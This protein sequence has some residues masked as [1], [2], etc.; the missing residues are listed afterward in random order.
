M[1]REAEALRDAG[2]EVDVVCMKGES[3][4][5]RELV[6]GIR[7]HRLGGTRR[8]A[9]LGAYVADYATFLVSATVTVARLDH[10][11][12]YAA[13]QVHTMPDV[14]VFSAVV[15][16]LRGARVILDMHEVMP[17]LFATKFGGV[18]GR[19]AA[20]LVTIAERASVGFAD[21]IL[22]VSEPT[23]RV[24]VGRGVRD[25]KLTIVMNAADERLFTPEAADVHDPALVISHGTIVERYGFRTLVRAIP[26]VRERR[27]EARLQ[28]VGDG[29]D[30][31]ELERLVDELALGDCV[32]LLGY[33]PL[34]AIP[35]LV[36]RAAV[37]VAANELDEFT[38]LIVP[39]KLM[40]YVEL[41]VPAVASRSPAVEEY[42]DERSIALFRAGDAADLARTLL[43]VLDDP[44]GS[45]SRAAEA[46]DEFRRRHGWA[47]Q[48][49]AYLE[50]VDRLLEI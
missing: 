44:A 24:L 3:E 38:A 10:R 29:E 9:G 50:A 4:R 17:E 22:T 1:R 40:E 47:K 2:F 37:G 49:A 14:L 5:D 13:V 6:G 43:A 48:R 27:P 34:D 18:A 21:L 28:I 12:R 30:L 26:L 7:V 42:F 8:R 11:R 20:R 19:L 35:E 15:P 23:R 33:R 25:E 46:R 16:K 31:V 41:G 45:R 32:E 36:A 39:T